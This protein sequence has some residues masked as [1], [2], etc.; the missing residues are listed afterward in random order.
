MYCKLFIVL[1]MSFTSVVG[2]AQSK[3]TAT[4]VLDYREMD[5]KMIVDVMV[6][7]RFLPFALDLAGHTTIL[8]KYVDEANPEKHIAHRLLDST[9]LYKDMSLPRLET[10]GW[11]TLGTVAYANNL[12]AC[13]LE[14]APYFQ[15]LG[16]AGVLGGEMFLGKVLTIDTQRKK[17]TVSTPTAPPY[18]QEDYQMKMELVAGT[19]VACEIILDEEVF[20][21]VLDTW[22]EGFVS[23][24]PEDFAKVNGKKGGKASITKGYL[25]TEKA[26]ATKVVAK[27]RFVNEELG[28]VVVAKNENLPRSI[29]GSDILRKGIVTI[30][31]KKQ[32]LYFQPF[33]LVKVQNDGMDNVV[34][35]IV[36]GK[37]N[38]INRKYFLEHLYDYRKDKEFIFK[39]NKPIVIDFWATWCKPCMQ[40]MPE[41]EKMAERYKDQVVFMKIDVDKE[42]ELCAVFNV[43]LIPMLL[44]VPVSGKPT[45]LEGYQP[46]KCEEIIQEQL[47]K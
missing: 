38:S 2:F 7:G 30:D 44:L 42:K 23:M 11:V 10:F 25:P 39:G 17:L 41:L 29:L 15:K 40:L 34:T 43:K 6:N 46:E 37:L 33:D 36:P 19:T 32:K 22:N 45:V 3:N 1:A 18:M 4:E 13:V 8:S 14:E 5:G 12:T 27:G 21:V 31:Y 26:T 16:I 24:T 20:P 28:E 35:E 47:L 9:F